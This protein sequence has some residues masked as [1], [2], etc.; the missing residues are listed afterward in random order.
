[1]DELKDYVTFDQLVRECEGLFTPYQLRAAL[2]RRH[3]NGLGQHV[4]KM[5]V[6]LYIHRQGF[7][8][9]FESTDRQ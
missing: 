8:E 2:R 7:V 5:G 9:W 6:R 1:M 3:Q 4:R